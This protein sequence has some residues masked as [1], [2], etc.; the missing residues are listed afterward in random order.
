MN[1]LIQH[2]FEL[3]I[4]WAAKAA[5][6]HIRSLS[7][8]E[9]LGPI[10]SLNRRLRVGFQSNRKQPNSSQSHRASDDICLWPRLSA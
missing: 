1:W 7:D 9:P 2:I 8:S 4:G 5:W 10:Y 6:P 3:V